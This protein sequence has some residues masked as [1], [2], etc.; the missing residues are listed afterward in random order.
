MESRSFRSMQVIARAAIRSCFWLSME[1]GEAKNTQKTQF[2]VSSDCAFANTSRMHKWP[3]FV[4]VN[5][6][7]LTAVEMVDSQCL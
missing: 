7:L 1:D 6:M 3:S 2:L 5:L 4:V